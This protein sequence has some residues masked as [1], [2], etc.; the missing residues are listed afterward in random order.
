MR[1]AA[2]AVGLALAAAVP[3]PKVAAAPPPGGGIMVAISLTYYVPGDDRNGI[4][5]VV[6][7][8]VPVVLVNA[9][10]PGE[11]A[12]HSLASNDGLFA[13]ELIGP[14][15]RSVVVGVDELPPGKYA[16]GCTVGGHEQYMT[17]HLTVAG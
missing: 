14:G 12:I 5:I 2:A 8:G 11:Q 17:G 9:E 7:R 3:S 13:S 6:P 4:G 15:E 1:S 16:F 10:I